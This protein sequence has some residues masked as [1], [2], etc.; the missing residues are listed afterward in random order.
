MEQIKKPEQ[1]FVH[2]I[3]LNLI[4]IHNESSHKSLMFFKIVLNSSGIVN[5]SYFAQHFS[6]FLYWYNTE[7][8]WTHFSGKRFSLFILS[9]KK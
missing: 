4:L 5:T 2:L 3:D 6:T 1:I 7:D 8:T 9:M